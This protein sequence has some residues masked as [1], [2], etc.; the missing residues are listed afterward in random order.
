M[1]A[2]T[3]SLPAMLARH[4]ALACFC[5]AMLVSSHPAWAEDSAS[6]GAEPAAFDVIDGFFGDYLVKPM[7]KI[8]FWDLTFW[9]NHISP[10]EGVGTMVGDK[11]VVAYDAQGYQLRAEQTL[12]VQDA[13]RVLDGPVSLD[14]GELS[15]DV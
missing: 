12:P 10:G 3:S 14:L 5:L 9:D 4:F 11:R 2:S 7:F 15:L 1:R 6:D 8:L 13:R